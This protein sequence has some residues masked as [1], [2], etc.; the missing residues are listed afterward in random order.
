MRWLPLRFSGFVH[1][2][3][4]HYARHLD[5]SHTYLFVQKIKAGDTQRRGEDLLAI[6]REVQRVQSLYRGETM[7]AQN[8]PETGKAAGGMQVIGL[9]ELE[10]GAKPGQPARRVVQQ[11]MSAQQQMQLTGVR[12]TIRQ[13]DELLDEIMLKLG[14]L[15]QINQ[16]IGDELELQ[17]EMLA[18]TEEQMDRAQSTLDKVNG[19]LDETLKVANAKST[20]FCSYA[21][22]I[23]ILLGI[24]VVLFNLI[25]G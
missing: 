15:E 8:D 1:C 18:D 23:F 4:W 20:T 2:S 13:Q 6:A 11:E 3:A 21:I 7:L 5:L 22:C 14:D 10:E 24:G 17:T 12:S 9:G 16:Q 19:R 25:T